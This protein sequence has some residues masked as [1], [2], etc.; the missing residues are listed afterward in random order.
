MDCPQMLG[1]YRRSITEF[2]SLNF[3]RLQ[4]SA[5]TVKPQTFRE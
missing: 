5:L 1:A 2:T 3:F 4:V